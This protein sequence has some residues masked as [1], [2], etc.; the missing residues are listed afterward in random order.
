MENNIHNQKVHK[1]VLLLIKFYKEYEREPKQGENY[2][3]IKIGPFYN[4]IKHGRTKITESDREMLEN[5]G[6]NLSIM[7]KSE[8]VHKKV[9]LLIEF[10]KEYG[11]EPKRNSN[12]KGIKIGQF[13]QSIK[14]GNTKITQS[15]RKMLENIGIKLSSINKLDEVHKKVLLLIE[16]YKE[17]G[18]TP[19]F[20]EEYHNI[21]IGQFF[22]SIK[23]G[24]TKIT[25]SDREILEN[26]GIKLTTIN[27]AEEVHKKVLLLIEFYKEY[28]REP[29]LKENYKDMKIG[30]FFSSIKSGSTKITE[31]D[32]EMLENIGLNI[33]IKNKVHKKVLLL[34]EFY[35]EYG[36]EPKWN[37][38]YKGT[39][40]GQF[41]NNIK[42]GRTKITESDREMLENIGIKL[43]S[44]KHKNT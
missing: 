40:I 33:S 6:L 17:Y 43:S 11:R 10:Y 27:R 30:Q 1:K 3:D 14:Y 13:F 38:N 25:E 39:N 2:K 32:R 15:D 12:Y 28:G 22:S 24:N 20:A 36:R 35:K 21:R 19:K 42:Y 4:N 23:S 5:V 29:K 18:R 8:R 9:L 37:S 44:T 7:N 34:I 41:Y 26:I 16:F 31:S